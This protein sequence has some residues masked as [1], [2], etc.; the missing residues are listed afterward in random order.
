MTR[1][2][3]YCLIVFSILLFLMLASGIYV[4]YTLIMPPSSP[5]QGFRRYVCNPIPKSV[6]G[7]R[8][9]LLAR[10]LGRH[11]YVFHF[12]ID[13]ADLSPILNVQ[14]SIFVPRPFQELQ[15][16]RYSSEN[17]H[18]TWA[19]E[20]QHI[21]GMAPIP[22]MSFSID[23]YKIHYGETEPEWFDLAKWDS[24]KA[25]VYEVRDVYR[26]FL[27]YNKNLGEAYF[28]DYRSPD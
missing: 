10:S 6:T 19:E 8:M 23:L 3:K 5:S 25:Y 13:E 7:I 2:F 26:L 24:P 27:V 21:E 11:T 1:N 12:K 4:F 20:L 16:F 14:H 22:R 28:I 17:G 15:Y 18:L 9:D